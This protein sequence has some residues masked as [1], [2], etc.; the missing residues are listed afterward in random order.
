MAKRVALTV[1]FVVALL[2]GCAGAETADDTEAGEAAGDL[3]SSLATEAPACA[4][5]ADEMIAELQG[6]VD[7]LGDVTLE[8]LAA[9]DVIEQDRQQRLEEL[10]ARVSETGCDD[11]IDQLL[12][13]R[14]E[15]IRG[16][17]AIA[18]AVRE[19]LNLGEELPF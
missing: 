16:E 1:V 4:E 3:A 8:E 19:S 14:A 13:E 12:A 10:E 9:G 18:D 6:I 17:G 15:Q 7:Q 11:Q 5:L 2:A